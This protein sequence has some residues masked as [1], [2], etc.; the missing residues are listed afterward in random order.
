MEGQLF[1]EILPEI[2]VH[3]NLREEKMETKN[4]IIFDI[5]DYKIIFF[6]HSLIALKITNLIEKIC[7]YRNQQMCLCT[8]Q[9]SLTLEAK[10]RCHSS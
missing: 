3:L 6:K 7:I 1:W 5:K 10:E 9:A 2:T 4:Y 8:I